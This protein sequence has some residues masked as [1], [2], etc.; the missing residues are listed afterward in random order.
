MKHFLSILLAV[1]LSISVNAQITV[2]PNSACTGET[3]TVTISGINYAA[4]S[5]GCGNLN[6]SQAG[7]TSGS[8]TN[9]VLNP[10][11]VT[12]VSG[13][14][15]TMTF[16]IPINFTPGI[17]GFNVENDCD[18][19]GSCSNCFTVETV[20]AQ[21]SITA[22]GTLLTSSSITGV[23][24]WFLNGVQIPGET[25]TTYTAVQSGSYTVE[26]LNNCG[27]SLPSAPVNIVISDITTLQNQLAH[28]Y[29]NP[30]ND[31]VVVE[32]AHSMPITVEMYDITG[33]LLTRRL[34]VKDA[35]LNTSTLPKGMYIIKL[36]SGNSTRIQKIV[37]Q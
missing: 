23:H 11:N 28:I 19:K 33:T 3:I 31:Y 18:A 17:Y 20:P 12:G 32:N 8:N 4:A 9:L 30:V 27:P 1:T 6:T 10:S 7:L 2:S 15:T 16:T 21:P 13:T 35:I 34:V 22:N 24:N 29:P 14:P 37:K 25:G 5:S 36:F 26:V